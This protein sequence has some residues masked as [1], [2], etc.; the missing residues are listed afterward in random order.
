MGPDVDAYS[1]TIRSQPFGSCR[2]PRNW[3]RA[4][5]FLKWAISPFFNIALA[6][7]VGDI[8]D[9][10]P[11]ATAHSAFT[12]IMAV[13]DLLVL[14]IEA[15]KEKPP[16]FHLELLGAQVDVHRD[17]VDAS[18]PARRVAVLVSDSESVLGRGGR[19]RPRPQS[20]AGGLDLR[21]PTYLD[22]LAVR[23]WPPYPNGSIPAQFALVTRLTRICAS[24]SGGG[25]RI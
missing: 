20:F 15:P 4:T 16:Y 11:R 25:L 22:G 2:A 17:Y 13:C 1:S 9:T 23:T 6:V 8:R 14:V 10:E 19:H 21:S 18:L 3:A 5:Q 24:P 12:T 7:Y